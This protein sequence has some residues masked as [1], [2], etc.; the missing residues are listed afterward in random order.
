MDNLSLEQKLALEGDLCDQLAELTGSL[1]EDER[2]TTEK[3]L[4]GE[5]ALVRNFGLGTS[6]VEGNDGH[7]RVQSGISTGKGY[8]NTM[9]G[10]GEGTG[11]GFG[12]RGQGGFGYRGTYY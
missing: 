10:Y 2:R 7:A 4:M 12:Y 3:Q 5:L 6:E 1:T 11:Y 9:Y 8:G